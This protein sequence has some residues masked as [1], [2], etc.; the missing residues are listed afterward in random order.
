MKNSILLF[1]VILSSHCF[2]HSIENEIK[3]DSSFTDSVAFIT[4]VNIENATKE[5]IYL[6]GYVVKISCRD[7]KKMDE[8]KIL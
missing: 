8:K 6:N 2:G 3:I 7:L 1:F 5:G 4:I